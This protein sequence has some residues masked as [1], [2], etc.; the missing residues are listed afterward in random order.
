MRGKLYIICIFMVLA[1]LLLLSNAPVAGDQSVEVAAI[2]PP[3]QSQ[4]FI[5][6]Q[7]AWVTQEDPGSNKEAS[8]F[9]FVGHSYTGYNHRTLVQFDLSGLPGDAQVAVATLELWVPY[10][11]AQKEVEASQAV[12]IWTRVVQSAWTDSTV[13]WNN[14][15]TAL[16]SKG[17]SG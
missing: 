1:T 12:T 6:T 2:P 5:V 13:T 8:T 16:A 17:I 4:T 10:N 14:Q 15:P 3:P 11:L 9:M 7:D